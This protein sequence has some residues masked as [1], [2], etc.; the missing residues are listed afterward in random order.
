M[1]PLL[2]ENILRT[3]SRDEDTDRVPTGGTFIGLALV[4]ANL[5]IESAK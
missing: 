3:R 4:A 1:D 2:C 5:E